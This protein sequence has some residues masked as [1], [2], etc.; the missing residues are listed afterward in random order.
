MPKPS[1]PKGKSGNPA[2]RPV[3]AKNKASFEVA[4]ICKLHECNPF[5]VLAWIASNNK[6]KLGV[7]KDMGI[8]IRKEAAAELCPYLA[9]TLKSIEHKGSAENPLTVTFNFGDGK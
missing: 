3:G 2:G 8:Y 1:F 9:P 7:D 5:E 4:E 6:E